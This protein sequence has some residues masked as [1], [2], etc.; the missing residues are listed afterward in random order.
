MQESDPSALLY[1][2]E[3]SYHNNTSCQSKT[4][5]FNI[6]SVKSPLG[7]VLYCYFNMTTIN[8]TDLTLSLE[9]IRLSWFKKKNSHWLIKDKLGRTVLDT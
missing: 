5:V 3:T 2:T 1:T 8:K 6:L 7:L 9:F 4:I